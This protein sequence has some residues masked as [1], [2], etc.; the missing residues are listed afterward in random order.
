MRIL[1][2]NEETKQNLLE[3]LLQ[4]SPDQYEEYEA[5][6]K[7][8]LKDVKERKDQ[9]IFDYTLKFD[10]FALSARNI[11]VTTQEIDD[12]FTKVDSELIRGLLIPK[13]IRNP[14]QKVFTRRIQSLF[15]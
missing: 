14:N 13:A 1:S 7:D 11:K 6:V 10:K 9:A 5:V 4:R 3:N 15:K 12:A 2:L 8:I